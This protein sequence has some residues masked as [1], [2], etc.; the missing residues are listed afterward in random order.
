MHSN[1]RLD[2]LAIGLSGLC[3]VH[4]VATTVLIALLSAAGGVLGAEWIHEVGLTIAMLLGAF[5]LY[6]GIAEHGFMM[7]S[8]V[9][10]L[11]LGVM[12][13]ALTLPH[14]GTEAAATI[15]GVLILAL[16]HDLNRRGT[17]HP[18]GKVTA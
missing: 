15:V 1:H 5:A 10:G 18:F 6:R 14:D 7:P 4:C 3:V 17:V 2:R 8:A 11:G 13:G 9:G 12:A 16:G